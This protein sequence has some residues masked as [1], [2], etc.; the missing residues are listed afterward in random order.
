ML[1]QPGS[2]APETQSMIGR[3]PAA[4]AERIAMSI[5]LPPENSTTAAGRIKPPK[6]G[7]V[8]GLVNF[9]NRSRSTSSLPDLNQAGW[10]ARR[11]KATWRCFASEDGG[12]VRSRRLPGRECF[13][14]ACHKQ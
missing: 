6:E 14:T 2:A 3:L 4:Y 9:G 13:L 1:G 10:F 5:T 12:A 7:T 11:H 8:F